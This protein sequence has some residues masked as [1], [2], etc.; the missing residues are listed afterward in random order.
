MV[1]DESSC[2]SVRVPMSIFIKKYIC[3]HDF[4]C[5]IGNYNNIFCFNELCSSHT[6]MQFGGIQSL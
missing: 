3:A 5:F 6:Y 2:T 1:L 4:G